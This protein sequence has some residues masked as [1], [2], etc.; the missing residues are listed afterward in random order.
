MKNSWREY[1]GITPELEIAQPGHTFGC[2]VFYAT[3]A[4]CFGALIYGMVHPS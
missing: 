4:A 2:L 1:F 3:L